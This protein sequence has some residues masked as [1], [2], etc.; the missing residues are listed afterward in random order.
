LLF[1]AYLPLV[2]AVPKV[3]QNGRFE[4]GVFFDWIFFHQLSTTGLIQPFLGLL[5]AAWPWSRPSKWVDSVHFQ[6][7]GIPTFSRRR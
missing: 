7:G 5:A 6:T 4:N 3:R 2:T 1:G